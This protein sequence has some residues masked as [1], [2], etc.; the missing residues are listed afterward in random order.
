M[1]EENKGKK[2]QDTVFRMYFDNAARLREV[3]GALHECTYASEED[4]KI[5]TL[6]GTF[7]SQVKNDVSFLL[8]GRH[9]ILIEHQSTEN[10]N[11]PL[12]CLY[13]VCEQFRKAV[14]AKQ[15][16]MKRRIE[17]PAPEFHVFFTADTE[18]PERWQMRLS[19]AYLES[20]AESSLEL[21]VTC[22]NIA[23]K[24]GRKLLERSRSLHDYSFFISRVKENIA[25]G[26]ER[27][28][29]IREAIRY[30]EEHGI[31][32][33][34]LKVHERE[35]VDM[36][37]FEWNQQEYEDAIREQGRERGL[38]QGLERGLEQGRVMVVLGLLKQKQPLETIADAA[39]L[40]L[41]KVRE[42]GRLHSLL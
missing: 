6:E 36:V 7:L 27:S 2:Y 9:L 29:A 21:T 15:L 10:E 8:S 25:A 24:S 37:N 35:V 12:R 14:S 31:M 17:L 5:V 38:E 40:P 30:C 19:D 18:L 1:G 22:H 42:I 32:E 39:E 34:F 16:Y 11:M 23:Y 3:A 33:E 20:G 28:K 41:E 13:Y 26:M 4:V